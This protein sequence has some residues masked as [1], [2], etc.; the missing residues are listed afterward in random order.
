M[1]SNGERR[2]ELVEPLT[3]YFVGRLLV[4]LRHSLYSSIL[5]SVYHGAYIRSRYY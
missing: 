2:E 3:N 1:D 4:V 5:L